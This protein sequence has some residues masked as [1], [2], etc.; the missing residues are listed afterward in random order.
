MF[1]L[2]PK[3]KGDMRAAFKYLKGCRKEEEFNVFYVAPQGETRAMEG[4]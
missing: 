3:L 1:S 2:E 4:A